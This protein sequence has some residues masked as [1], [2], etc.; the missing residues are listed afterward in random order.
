LAKKNVIIEN[1]KIRKLSP[2]FE[3]GVAGTVNYQTFTYFC[4]PA[5]VVDLRGI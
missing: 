3:G 5:G 2:P 4:F 1:A